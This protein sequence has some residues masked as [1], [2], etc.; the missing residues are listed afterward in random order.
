VLLVA[1]PLLGLLLRRWSLLVMPLIAWPIYGIGRNQR[2]WGC[3]GTGEFWEIG[4]LGLA[5]FGV[6]TTAAAVWLGQTFAS[7]LAK[8][9]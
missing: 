8:P 2:W 5:L 3:C 1:L 4:V 9:S 6:L 7:R